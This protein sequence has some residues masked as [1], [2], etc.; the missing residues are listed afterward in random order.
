MSYVRDPFETL[1][2]AVHSPSRK[3]KMHYINNI[4]IQFQMTH[5]C[6]RSHEPSMIPQVH[7]LFELNWIFRI[8]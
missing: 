7:R 3:K 5:P 6:L 4:F 1:M 8:I 2:K